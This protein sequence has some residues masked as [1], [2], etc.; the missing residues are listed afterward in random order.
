M[1][2]DIYYR[3]LS[4]LS[5]KL[6]KILCA[7][8]KNSTAES[9]HEKKWFSPFLNSGCSNNA[10]SCKIDTNY[11]P[12][13]LSRQVCLWLVSSVFE[14]GISL[15]LKFESAPHLSNFAALDNGPRSSAAISN[16]LL[17]SCL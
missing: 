6:W 1:R 12:D 3:M 11:S 13:S 10:E 4:E 15:Y 5:P 2:R 17:A 14:R 7:L 9:N 8:L 16:T